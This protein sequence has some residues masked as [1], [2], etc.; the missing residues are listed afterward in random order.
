MKETVDCLLEDCRGL[1]FSA[2]AAWL[3]RLPGKSPGYGRHRRTAWFRASR[4]LRR[5]APAALLALSASI[6]LRSWSLGR[7]ALELE[8]VTLAWPGA[9]SGDRF[10]GGGDGRRIR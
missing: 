5:V 1:L 6:L 9:T 8:P 7:P 4:E 10:S 2:G 3:G